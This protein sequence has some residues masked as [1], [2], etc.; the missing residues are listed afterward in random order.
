[1]KTAGRKETTTEKHQ[2]A[3]GDRVEKLCAVCGEERGHVVALLNVRGHI[4]RV[5]CPQCGTR[6]AFKSS[7]AVSGERA[8]TRESASYDS[9]RTYRKGQT[10]MHPTFGLGEVTA[11]IE[12]QKID[13]LFSDRIRRLI[14][15]RAQA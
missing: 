3:V 6:S 4:S 11:V 2:Y 14:H 10:M 15:G 7:K 12:A 5:S 13:V 9:S 1:M 8:L